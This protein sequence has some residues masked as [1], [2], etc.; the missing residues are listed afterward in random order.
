[1][2]SLLLGFG[3]DVAILCAAQRTTK[4]PGQIHKQKG[5]FGCTGLAAHRSRIRVR[6][7]V[8]QKVPLPMPAHKAAVPVCTTAPSLKKRNPARTE[9]VVCKRSSLPAKTS[10]VYQGSWVRFPMRKSEAIFSWAMTEPRY[11]GG[12]S[13]RAREYGCLKRSRQRRFVLSHYK[14]RLRTLLQSG[15]RPFAQQKAF[16]QAKPFARID[17]LPG[18]ARKGGRRWRRIRPRKGSRWR[19]ACGGTACR[20]TSRGRRGPAHLRS[21]HAQHFSSGISWA[22]KVCANATSLW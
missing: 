8:A 12:R 2:P 14:L 11:C 10:R 16:A 9:A 3:F 19:C 7:I 15:R 1:M 20:R 18:R 5:R 6:A 17:A 13:T 21:R 4:R 22:S